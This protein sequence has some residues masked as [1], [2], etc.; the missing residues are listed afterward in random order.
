[1]KT[2]ISILGS[3][4][5]VLTGA[6]SVLSQSLIATWDMTSAEDTSTGSVLRYCFSADSSC[7]SGACRDPVRHCPL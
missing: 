1:M 6:R 4:I 3:L 7:D 2:I 5:L